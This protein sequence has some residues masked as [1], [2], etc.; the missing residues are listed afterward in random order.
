M[1][2][3]VFLERLGSGD[4]A[5]LPAQQ[6]LWMATQGSAACLGL[7]GEIGSLEVG[8][9]ADLILLDLRVGTAN[10]YA[11]KLATCL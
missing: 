5:A 10:R 11:K 6:A 4:G 8:K 3:A 7:E 9:K 2:L 1:R